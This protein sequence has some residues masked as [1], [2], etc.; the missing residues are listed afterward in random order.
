MRKPKPVTLATSAQQ[1]I[2]L[3][4]VQDVYESTKKVK[5][6]TNAREHSLTYMHHLGRLTDEQLIAGNLFRRHYEAATV[7]GVTGLDYSR[8]RV[9][10][11]VVAEPLTERMQ[12]AHRWLREA[13]KI[14]GIGP[15]GFSL[16]QR[17]AGDGEGIASVARSWPHSKASVQRMEGYISG[18]LTECL[19]MLVE[20][21]GLVAKG[22]VTK[23]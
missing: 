18:R 9:D 14:P 2:V 22:R 10:G 17:V 8:I 11:G 13:S 6:A 16:L 7:G 20:Y 1:V 21:Y 15:V 5:V 12:D 4:E 23:V 3:S 19:D